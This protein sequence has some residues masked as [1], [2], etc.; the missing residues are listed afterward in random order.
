M[1][2]IIPD[3]IVYPEPAKFFPERE[4]YNMQKYNLEM[5]KNKIALE[6]RSRKYNGKIYYKDPQQYYGP[7]QTYKSMPE[8]EPDKFYVLII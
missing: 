3:E 6:D 1:V 5:Q 4:I 8:P 2:E 7:Q